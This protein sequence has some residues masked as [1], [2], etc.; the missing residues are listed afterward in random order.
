MLYQN[1]EFRSVLKFKSSVALRTLVINMIHSLPYGRQWSFAVVT[2]FQ[3]S[4]KTVNDYMETRMNFLQRPVT[5]LKDSQRP[6]R[7]DRLEVYLSD[8]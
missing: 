1:A 6:G 5:T 8:H 4:S 2:K 3:I 7:W